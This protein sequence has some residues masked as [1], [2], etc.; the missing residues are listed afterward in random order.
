MTKWVAS[1]GIS[2]LSLPERRDDQMKSVET[3][4]QVFAKAPLCGPLFQIAVG[5]GDHAHVHTLRLGRA[6]AVRFA[7]LYQTQELSLIAGAQ[8]RNPVQKERA[9]HGPAH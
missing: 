5:G 6:Y 8:L 7:V 9:A 2:S 4:E 3:I 1:R